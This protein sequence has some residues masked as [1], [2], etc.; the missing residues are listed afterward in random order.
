[1]PTV[2][3][4][5]IKVL[6]QLTEVEKIVIFGPKDPPKALQETMDPGR[7][8]YIITCRFHFVQKSHQLN[9]FHLGTGYMLHGRICVITAILKFIGHHFLQVDIIKLVRIFNPLQPMLTAM[10]LHLSCL[11]F[12]VLC[13]GT[14]KQ[15]RLRL[16]IHHKKLRQKSSQAV[17]HPMN[18]MP[19]WCFSVPIALF[20]K[21]SPNSEL[22][23]FEIRLDPSDQHRKARPLRNGPRLTTARS[24]RFALLLAFFPPPPP[25]KKVRKCPRN[26]LSSPWGWTLVQKTYTQW[27]ELPWWR[28]RAEFNPNHKKWWCGKKNNITPHILWTHPHHPHPGFP[29][30]NGGQW[31]LSPPISEPSRSDFSGAHAVRDAKPE[32]KNMEKM[33]TDFPWNTSCLMTRSLNSS[34]FPNQPGFFSLLKWNLKKF[35]ALQTSTLKRSS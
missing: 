17:W 11:S 3:D 30:E 34:F 29:G 7:S 2:T 8:H 1:M 22:P 6:C 18:F 9:H 19:S 20:K 16:Q 21:K 33:P 10:H 32:R 15:T 5:F 27:A 12:V 31:D 23:S 13:H 14:Q 28:G 26:G 35:E 4:K 24:G 25:K